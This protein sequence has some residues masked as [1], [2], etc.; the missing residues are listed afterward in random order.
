MMCTLSFNEI[1]MIDEGILKSDNI[2]MTAF[3][4]LEIW[5]V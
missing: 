3:K 2:Q 1:R 4:T 5:D